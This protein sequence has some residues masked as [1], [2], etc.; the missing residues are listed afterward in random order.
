MRALGSV[1]QQT[2][3]PVEIVVVDDSAPDGTGDAIAQQ[4]LGIRVRILRSSG[5]LGPAA[6]RNK[7]IAAATGKYIA[8]LDIDSHWLPLK[9]ARQ[10]AAAGGHPGGDGIVIYSQREIRSRGKSIAS[11]RWAIG[12]SEK[13]ADYLLANGGC[14][15][16]ATV[17]VSTDLARKVMYRPELRQHEDWDWYIRLEQHG[18]RFLMVPECLC[19]LSDD[20]AERSSRLARPNLSLV[21]LETWKPMISSRAYFA[22]RAAIAPHMRKKTLL[23]ALAMIVGA[24]VRGAITTR[25]LAVLLRRLVQSEQ[26]E[27]G[28]LPD[29]AVSPPASRGVS[30][31][32]PD[33]ATKTAK[34]AVGRG[35]RRHGQP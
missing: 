24:Y 11:P 3:R 1:V 21:T 7:G 19:I 30:V 29:P 22:F 20:D 17:L 13:V 25:S 33:W 31:P 10:V 34:A 18:A 32:S 26:R 5:S 23:P 8:F 9:L 27:L 4:D 6:A 15:D 14:I 28:A 35:V 2:Y 12:E 16:P